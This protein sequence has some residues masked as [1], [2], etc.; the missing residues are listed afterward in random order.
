MSS[1]DGGAGNV[2]QRRAE[3]VDADVGEVLLGQ[4]VARERDVNDRNGGGPV[5][6]N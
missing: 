2:N 6:Q 4:A 3:L 1:A 5:V